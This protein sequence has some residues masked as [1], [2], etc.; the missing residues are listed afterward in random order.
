MVL[1]V[2]NGKTTYLCVNKQRRFYGSRRNLFI[3]LLAM[4]A[5]S[6]QLA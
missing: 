6:M 5:S 1:R 3:K 2:G 4:R